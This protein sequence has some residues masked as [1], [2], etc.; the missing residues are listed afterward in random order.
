MSRSV[1]GHQAWDMDLR[2][3]LFADLYLN[4]SSVC[5]IGQTL[6]IKVELGCFMKCFFAWPWDVLYA[7]QKSVPEMW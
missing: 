3:E 5:I 6:R 2:T 1:Q 4:V 7:N